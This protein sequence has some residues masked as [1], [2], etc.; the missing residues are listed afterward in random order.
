VDDA[1]IDLWANWNPP[2]YRLRIPAGEHL[3][4]LWLPLI[5]LSKPIPKAGHQHPRRSRIFLFSFGFVILLA[6]IALTKLVHLRSGEGQSTTPRSLAIL[7]LQNRGED[8]TSDF[9]GLSL[10]SRNWPQFE[11]SG[12]GGWNIQSMSV[13]KRR[14]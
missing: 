8:S 5:Q 13:T 14:K 1:V 6:V 11:G 4:L 7:P 12:L 2:I 3:T 10:A 9:L